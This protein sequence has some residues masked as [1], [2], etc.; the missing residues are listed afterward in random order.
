MTEQESY[1]KGYKQGYTD[2][3]EMEKALRVEDCI[4]R[5]EARIALLNKGQHSTRYKLG[6][7]WELNLFEIEEVLNDL[8]SVK[9]TRDKGLYGVEI[10]NISA[11]HSPY[12]VARYYEE[13]KSWWYWGRYDT[14]ERAE[15]AAAEIGG[16]V[17]TEVK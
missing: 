15:E 2:R 13:T 10:N 9:P 4:S 7:T 11:G 16:A 5:K 12:I 17:F 6:Q 1:D 8:P 3:I 14:K